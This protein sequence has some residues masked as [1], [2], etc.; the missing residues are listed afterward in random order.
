MENF[1]EAKIKNILENI[2]LSFSAV[3]LLGGINFGEKKENLFDL[4][5]EC[6][7]DKY[8]NLFINDSSLISEN[9]LKNP[10]GAIMSIAQR[11]INHFIKEN[12]NDK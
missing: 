1:D 11:N 4:Y 8:K 3:H 12:K 9:L 7:I 5:G 6:K 10:Q 2:K